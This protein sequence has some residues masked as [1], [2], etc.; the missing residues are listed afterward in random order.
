M[1]QNIIL[2]AITTFAFALWLAWLKRQMILDDDEPAKA[3][4]RI[5]RLKSAAKR[6]LNFPVTLTII[7]V[8][9]AGLST[10][11]FGVILTIIGDIED[12]LTGLVL[13]AMGLGGSGVPLEAL[14]QKRIANWSYR[15]ALL[16][17][18]LVLILIGIAVVIEIHAWLGI[19]AILIGIGGVAHSVISFIGSD[20]A[21]RSEILTLGRAGGIVGVIGFGAEFSTLF[22][23]L[24]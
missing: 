19:L 1:D 10:A 17:G 16:L 22:I 11:V 2:G 24:Q 5:E 9:I 3:T 12:R 18:G 21:R 13:L 4:A 8:L 23:P 20:K 7:L 14:G 6:V 15:L